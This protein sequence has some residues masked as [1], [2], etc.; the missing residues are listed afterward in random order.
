MIDVCDRQRERERE[1]ESLVDR[2][3]DGRLRCSERTNE[4]VGHCSATSTSTSQRLQRW[5]Q[6]HSHS[7][8]AVAAASLR[9]LG[10]T[11]LG[12]SGVLLD[13]NQ[14]SLNLIE[15]QLCAALKGLRGSIDQPIHSAHQRCCTPLRRHDGRRRPHGTGTASY[16]F[17]VVTGLGRGLHEEQVVIERKLLALLALDFAL[18]LKV[19]YIDSFKASNASMKQA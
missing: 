15:H 19:T 16:S 13:R 7:L 8:S 14:A 1:R 11:Q 17:D 12:G 5:C 4:R 10:R 6:T 2:W 18:A 9:L 3:L